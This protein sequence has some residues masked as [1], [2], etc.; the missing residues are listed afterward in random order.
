MKTENRALTG[1]LTAI[2][3]LMDMREDKSL[4]F[5]SLEKCFVWADEEDAFL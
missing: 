5:K 2:A 1:D 3:A 4:V